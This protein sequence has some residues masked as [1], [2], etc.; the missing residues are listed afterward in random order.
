MNKS[1]TNIIQ[2]TY[3]IMMIKLITIYSIL[4][5]HKHDGTIDV[6]IH[7]DFAHVVQC[8]YARL[9]HPSTTIR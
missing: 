6:G 4:C 7:I 9:S 3:N 5:V 1:V 8:M 2:Y